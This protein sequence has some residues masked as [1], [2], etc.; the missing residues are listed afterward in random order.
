MQD[1]TDAYR[2][3]PVDHWLLTDEALKGKLWRHHRRAR[4]GVARGWWLVAPAAKRERGKVRPRLG[5]APPSPAIFRH[6]PGFPF[7]QLCRNLVNSSISERMDRGHPLMP[8]LRT[9]SVIPTWLHVGSESMILSRGPLLWSFKPSV[10]SPLCTNAVHRASVA[11]V[12]FA[13]A[14]LFTVYFARN[15]ADPKNC[16]PSRHSRKS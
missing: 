8:R 12:K 13:P 15:S 3:R 4:A 1:I 6:S 7:P 9:V 16:L 14:D 5:A 2:A 11:E 10:P